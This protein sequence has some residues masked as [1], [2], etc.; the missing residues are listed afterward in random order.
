MPHIH[1]AIGHITTMVIA[2]ALAAGQ[3]AGQAT[4]IAGAL[5]AGQ[6]TLAA[7][8]LVQRG[9]VLTAHGAT[10]GRVV[11]LVAVLI[12]NLIGNQTAHRWL[13]V[14]QLPGRCAN[15]TRCTWRA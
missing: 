4:L 2:G 8:Q 5:A 12:G 6:A 15:L 3:A 7:G 1:V 11:V 10:N 9:V 13:N 14:N